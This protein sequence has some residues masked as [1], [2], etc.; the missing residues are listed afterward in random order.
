[1]FEY[2]Q[3]SKDIKLKKIIKIS[4]I[5]LIVTQYLLGCIG[6]TIHH[7]CCEKIY[8]TS[9]PL[10]DVISPYKILNCEKNHQHPEERKILKISQARC[11]ASYVY[12]IDHLKYSAGDS[13]NIPDLFFDNSISIYTDQ[14]TNLFAHEF[15]PTKLKDDNHIFERWRRCDFFCLFLI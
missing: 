9:L 2:N 11:C 14:I 7:C 15:R 3:L 10:A 1:M 5:S 6:F 12:A 13:V 4:L 8:H